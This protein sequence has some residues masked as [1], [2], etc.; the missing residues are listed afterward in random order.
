MSFRP[1]CTHQFLCFAGST[2]SCITVHGPHLWLFLCRY[3]QTTRLLVK[4]KRIEYIQLLFSLVS[5]QC[6]YA[7]CFSFIIFH[8]RVITAVSAFEQLL[9]YANSMTRLTG[10]FQIPFLWS[11][12]PLVAQKV[13]L[14]NIHRGAVS[15]NYHW[16]VYLGVQFQFDLFGFRILLFFGKA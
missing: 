13:S 16:T 12:A 14:N 6:Q 11:H 2:T 5:I 7:F 9:P 1:H 10:S 4:K 3:F 8:R 15:D